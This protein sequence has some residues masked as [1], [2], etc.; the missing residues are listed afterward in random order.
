MTDKG[1]AK[2]LEKEVERRMCE[3]VRK[4]GGLTYKF[5]SQNNPGVPDRIIITPG[6]GVWF[7]ELKAICGRLAKIQKWQIGE[8]E[9]RGAN[10]RVVHGWDAAK[11]F[12]EEVMPD[13]R[14]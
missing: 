9:K 12:I 5:T 4:R 6:G 10:V 8:L 14:I 1:G 11:E 2:M 13:G 7:V 3:M